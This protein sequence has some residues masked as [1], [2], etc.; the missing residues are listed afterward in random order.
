M[1]LRLNRSLGVFPK[2]T[3]G[4]PGEVRCGPPLPAGRGR[5]LR[6]AR[7]RRQDGAGALRADQRAAVSKGGRREAGEREGK[8]GREGLVFVFWGELLSAF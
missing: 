4:P 6:R 3:G 7:A 5:Q 1:S 2:A 8:E